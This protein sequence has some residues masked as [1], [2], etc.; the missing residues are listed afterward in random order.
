MRTVEF[1][2]VK[3]LE[4]GQPCAAFLVRR[5]DVNELTVVQSARSYCVDVHRF[6]AA[7]GLAPAHY[8]PLGDPH[9]PNLHI[10]VMEYVVGQ[11]DAL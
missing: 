1:D 4:R 8:G 3:P 11:T 2:Y 9:A 7:E 10:V 6:M 5:R